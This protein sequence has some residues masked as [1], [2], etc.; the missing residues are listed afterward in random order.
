[1][2][3]NPV[4]QSSFLLPTD[5]LQDLELACELDIFDTDSPL[6]IQTIES[7]NIS[8]APVVKGESYDQIL[9]NA[10]L[11]QL[12]DDKGPSKVEAEVLI[13]FMTPDELNALPPAQKKETKLKILND[14]RDRL[15]NTDEMIRYEALQQFSHFLDENNIVLLNKMITDE[16][17]HIRSFIVDMAATIGN[18]QA[19]SLLE[20]LK[21]DN[22]SSVASKALDKLSEIDPRYAKPITTVDRKKEETQT[23]VIPPKQDDSSGGLGGL[24]KKF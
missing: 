13:T 2:T 5:Q 18:S 20:V 8:D 3:N 1:E 14:I 21:R 6:V 7:V 22:D 16:S 12:A 23:V 15:A 11:S 4:V 24:F 10:D 19:L 9:M 17:V